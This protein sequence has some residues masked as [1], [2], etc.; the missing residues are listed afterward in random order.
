MKAT[1]TT[2]TGFLNPNVKWVKLL[3]FSDYIKNLYFILH[4]FYEYNK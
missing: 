1:T 4:K 3:K 2:K